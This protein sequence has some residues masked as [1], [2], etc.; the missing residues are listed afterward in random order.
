M[1]EKKV[2]FR[3]YKGYIFPLSYLADQ[4]MIDAIKKA[5]DFSERTNIVFSHYEALIR[6]A[7][8][9]SKEIA[10]VT[11]ILEECF[12][13]NDFTVSVETL[14][15]HHSIS[16]RTL[17]RYFEKCT[18]VSSKQALQIMRIRKA[19]DHLAN[20][21]QTFSNADYGYYDY[22][23][24]YKHLRR[25]LQKDTLSNLKP[26]LLLLNRMNKT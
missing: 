16:S 2:N 19:A 7:G 6:T 13:T 11:S 20:H 21:R 8:N 5:K 10:I 12:R 22:S 1:L 3:E 24:F 17:Q 9:P 4:S 26:H 23:H 25:F 18:G 14:A 15:K